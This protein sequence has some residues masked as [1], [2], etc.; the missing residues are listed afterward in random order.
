MTNLLKS[1][2]LISQP[3]LPNRRGTYYKR[4]FPKTKCRDGCIWEKNRMEIP[5]TTAQRFHEPTI[6]LN[7][8]LVV[9]PLVLE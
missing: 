9:N 8:V 4:T 6:F 7:T 5:D 1:M 2:F 3:T